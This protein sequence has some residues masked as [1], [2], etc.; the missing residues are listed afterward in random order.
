MSHCLQI[1]LYCTFVRYKEKYDN[2][3]DVLS[4]HADRGLDVR[5]VAVGL[6]TSNIIT[7]HL[8]NCYSLACIEENHHKQI[9]YL[10]EIVFNI[11]VPRKDYNRVTLQSNY[12]YHSFC[13]F[14]RRHHCL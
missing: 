1:R 4:L 13:V 6:F 7:C 10:S 8:F 5:H 12:R 14:M 11:Y 9:T 3:K 2:W